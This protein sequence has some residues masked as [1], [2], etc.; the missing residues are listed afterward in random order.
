[1]TELRHNT[2][3]LASAAAFFVAG[4]MSLCAG[5][6]TFHPTIEAA[7]EAEA[8]VDP[9][10]RLPV[11][12]NF[13]AAWC[14]WCRKMEV[15]TFAD[16]SVEAMA[17]QFLWVKVDSD[18]EPVLSARFRVQGLPH[19]F[20]LNEDDR[21]IAS[22]P[23]YIPPGD[24][25]TF[26]GDALSNPQPVEDLMYDLLQQLAEEQSAEERRE[27]IT[28]VVEQLAKAERDGRIEALEAL[29][30]FGPVV[31]GVLVDLLEDERLAVRAA[32][33]GTLQAIARADLQFDAF[34]PK[35]ERLQQSK[36]WRVWVDESPGATEGESS[37]DVG[38]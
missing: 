17:D 7:R 29:A 2:I 5:E 23:G 12:L 37:G 35:D 21:T 19:T 8:A 38:T 32:S 18:E 33:A 36:L 27:T 28:A 6:I 24:F 4:P 3:L 11:V 34:A 20:V 30:D 1:M 16:E 9:A 13:G 15:D 22:R 25:V 26:L 14:G 31:W 10:E